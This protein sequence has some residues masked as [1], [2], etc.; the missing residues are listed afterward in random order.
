M[1]ISVWANLWAPFCGANN[2][3]FQKLKGELIKAQ[4]DHK[5]LW[6]KA[7]KPACSGL[8]NQSSPRDGQ[9]AVPSLS[10]PMNQPA[11]VS[12][13]SAQSSSPHSSP[14]CSGRG[15]K[16]LFL[17]FYLFFKM[18]FSSFVS[19][20]FFFKTGF[21]NYYLFFKLDFSTFISFSKWISQTL[22]LFTLDFSTFISFLKWI[23]QLLSLFRPADRGYS[24]YV[25]KKFKF[26]SGDQLAKHL[27]GKRW[28]F[29]KKKRD[30]LGIFSKR[31]GG[32]P[33]F[34]KML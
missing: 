25:C 5:N 20:F 29:Q 22:S 11:V 26:N 13:S 32:S 21:L 10:P 9:M 2:L 7:G 27:L 30:F 6:I 18:D 17:N 1:E 16:R 28:D 15:T 34:P 19:P 12:Q 31:G 23:S 33:Q 14:A 8:S 24:C 3:K 4:N